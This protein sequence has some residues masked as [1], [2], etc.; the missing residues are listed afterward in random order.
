MK[1]KWIINLVTIVILQGLLP[2]HSFA[3]SNGSTKTIVN[4]S[5]SMVF[6]SYSISK[7]GQVMAIAYL[8]DPIPG[9]RE[10]FN[11]AYSQNAGNTWNVLKDLTNNTGAFNF[12]IEVSANGQN[13]SVVWIEDGINS[14]IFF[15]NSN[16]KGSTWSEA[17]EIPTPNVSTAKHQLRFSQSDDGK[18]KMITYF[19]NV[20]NGSE[21]MSFFQN[22]SSDFGATWRFSRNNSSDIKQP[23]SD[24]KVSPDGKYFAYSYE[25]Y[26]NKET[27]GNLRFSISTDGINWMQEQTIDS[28][29]NFSPDNYVIRVNQSEIVILYEN[30]GSLLVS[31]DLGKSFKK[32]SIPVSGFARNIWLS[33]DSKQ[34]ISTS[35]SSSGSGRVINLISSF[36]SGINWSK[37]VTIADGSGN[38]SALAVGDNGELIA[39]LYATWNQK[40]LMLMMSADNGQTWGQPVKINAEGEYT[41]VTRAGQ[42]LGLYIDQK[43][44]EIVAFNNALSISDKTYSQQ[45]IKVP[46]YQIEFEGDSNTGGMVPSKLISVKGS[47]IALPA[48][49]IDFVKEHNKF[50]GWSKI[51]DASGAIYLPGQKIGGISSD[52]KLVAKWEELPNFNVIFMP[53]DYLKQNPGN[54]KLWS[55]SKFDLPEV[56]PSNLQSNRLFLEWNTKPDGTGVSIKPGQSIVST[57]F[58]NN[59]TGDLKLYAIGKIVV[60]SKP[61]AKKITIKCIKGTKVVRISSA[62]P[63]CPSGFKKS[64]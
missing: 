17:V 18:V 16:D 2:Q 10:S 20:S 57:Y 53:N 35:K 61:I 62:N 7:D 15:K 37:Q 32:T 43:S 14:K 27:L 52:L 22:T 42:K 25:S 55:D 34:I 39:K 13:I 36:N 63:R 4:N 51:S 11:I 49:G 58:S 24:S 54:S 26:G 40:D 29:N 5:T 28:G 46:Y 56:L 50:L 38:D 44:K 31:S 47:D 6:P 30:S 23:Y 33:P 41:R 64:N 60:P 1:K 9:K 59:L 8:E 21:F 48:K 12:S 19:A 3:N 45:L